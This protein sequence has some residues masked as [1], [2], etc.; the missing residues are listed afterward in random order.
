MGSQEGHLVS[1]WY[2]VDGGAT[3]SRSTLVLDLAAPA[4]RHYPARATHYQVEDLAKG[5]VLTIASCSEDSSR[6]SSGLCP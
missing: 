6:W 1:R 2:L 3:R 5:D 4:S